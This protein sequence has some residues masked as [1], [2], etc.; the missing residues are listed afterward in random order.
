MFHMPSNEMLGDMRSLHYLDMIIFVSTPS[1]ICRTS[2][3]SVLC[4][5]VTD[6]SGWVQVSVAKCLYDR[7]VCSLAS[8]VQSTLR[9]QSSGI[10]YHFIFTLLQ[11]VKVYSEQD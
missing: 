2:K 8:S 10:L 3:T 5:L 6:C 11:L 1:L 4:I 7:L 9:L